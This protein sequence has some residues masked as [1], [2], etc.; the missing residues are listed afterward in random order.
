MANKWNELKQ[1]LFES[2]PVCRLCWIRP[3][4]QLHH[5]V[6]NKAKVRNKK[7]HKYLDNKHN[8]LEVCE[9]CHPFADAYGIRQTAW[10][11]NCDRYGKSSMV[12]WY[13]A[14]PLKIK[15]KFA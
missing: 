1:E 15:E 13:D 9:V 8:A 11:I 7:L 3:A 5:A 6:I 2:H 12:A 14:L 4:T 10:T